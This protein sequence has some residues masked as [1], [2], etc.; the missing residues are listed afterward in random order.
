[1]KRIITVLSFLIAFTGIPNTVH[2]QDRHFTWTYESITLPK[3]GIDIEPW[4]TY[5]TG[6]E[7][8]YNRY[9]TRLEF[10]TGLT[11]R[12]QTA[13]Y[14][15]AKHETRALTDSSGNITGLGKSS[16]YSFSNEWKLNVLNPSTAPIGLGLYAEYGISPD[17]IELEFKLLLDKKM[18]K[19]IIAYNF[20]NEFEFEYE[21][22]KKQNGEGEIESEKE[23]IIEN[24]LAYMY[25][26]K[27]NFGLGV[28]ARNHNEFVEGE[29]EHAVVFI[30]PTLFYSQKNFFAIINV[31]PQLFNLK[32]GGREL[33]EHEKFSARILLGISL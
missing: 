5:Y 9:E 25:L 30:G 33:N 21:F 19:S 28:E 18:P 17:E 22:E 16:G 10:E 2:A 14:F 20:V 8:Y 15:N 32:G 31:L 11:N 3:G 26:F 7:N 29:M 1:M 23:Y 12:L 4:V 13:L 6:R 24:D 27:P